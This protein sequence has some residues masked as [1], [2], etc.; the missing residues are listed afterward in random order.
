MFLEP[1]LNNSSRE[2]KKLTTTLA[3]FGHDSKSL[4]PIE[5]SKTTILERLV[6]SNSVFSS[7]TSLVVAYY[8][9][10]VFGRLNP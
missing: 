6:L 1:R 8:G 7:L 3:Q 2:S 10:Q 5:A 4:R 9:Q